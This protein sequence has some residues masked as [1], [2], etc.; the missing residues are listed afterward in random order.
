MNKTFCNIFF[1]LILLYCCCLFDIKEIVWKR[2]AREKIEREGEKGEKRGKERE[3]S[4]REVESEMA[5]LCTQ[6][7]LQN[8]LFDLIW[9][10]DLGLK[11][12]G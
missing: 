10:L 6:T 9:I 7:G 8:C 3:K 12:K 4:M 2:D 11:M 5:L 1:L